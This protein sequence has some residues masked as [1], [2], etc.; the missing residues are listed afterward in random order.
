[1]IA[2]TYRAACTRE[3]ETDR[4][5][6]TDRP[7][8]QRDRQTVWK[9]SERQTHT[10]THTQSEKAGARQTDRDR[11]REHTNLM[12]RSTNHSVYKTVTVTWNSTLQDVVELHCNPNQPVSVFVCC[13]SL[14]VWR[15]TCLV[16][17]CTTPPPIT[18]PLH[19]PEQALTHQV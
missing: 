7:D 5:R 11:E 14:C 13:I 15:S 10:H 17:L 9:W 4:G 18:S 8:R 1:M 16:C 2:V 3:R 19:L 12:K 6:Q